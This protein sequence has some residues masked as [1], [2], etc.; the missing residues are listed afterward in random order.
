MMTHRADQA[1]KPRL[2]FCSYHSYL[3][4]SSGAAISMRDL[5]EMAVAHGWE[6]AALSGPDLDLGPNASFEALLRSRGLAFQ[7]RPGQVGG[8]PS[9]LYHCVENGVA[10]HAFI[11]ADA[12][13]RQPP[14]REQGHAFLELLAHVQQRFR[15]DI[16]LTYGGQWVAFPLIRQARQRGARVVFALRN[17]DYN[18]RELFE[19][20]DAILVPSRASQDYYREKLG[21]TS[22]AVPGP[23]NWERVLCPQVKRQYLTFVNPQ[24]GK[25]VIWVARLA[26]EMYRRRPDIPF[27]IVEGRARAGALAGSGLDLRGLTNLHGMANTPDPRQFYRV[28]RAMLMPSLAPETFGRVVV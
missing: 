1:G 9:T 2:L 27:L 28:S 5:L 21:L 11:P 25:G 13:P 23:F 15:P 26:Q 14:T 19:N 17:F 8:V 3:D 12:R 16:V 24:P 22:T 20:V 10:I 18:G 6:C 4:P 7:F